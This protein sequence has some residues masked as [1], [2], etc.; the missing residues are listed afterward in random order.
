ME[1]AK[2]VK[3]TEMTWPEVA[4]VD[5]A[6]TLVVA[7]IAACEQHSR[8]LAVFTDAILCGGIADGV[9]ANLPD[10]VL[11]LP[12]QWMGASDHHL[13]FGAT[14]SFPVA[15]HAE[16]VT[17]LLRPF[18]GDG[19]GRFL[20]LNGHGGN[21]DTFHVALR[22]LQPEYPDRL[23]AGACYW[24]IAEKEI[25]ELAT[26]PRKAVG[27]ACE[28]ETAMMMHFRP[29]L[30]RVEE[31]KDDHQTLPDELRGLFLAEDM[32]QRTERGCVGYPESASAEMGKRLVDAI[33][34]RVTVACRALL[35]RPIVPGGG[36][37]YREQ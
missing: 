21:V 3:L 32:G 14:L 36:K 23:L 8:H 28:V 24:E 22:S 4:K 29:D 31:R 25:A 16:M 13:P 17:H 34:Q 26:G 20:V 27:H 30:V 18:L 11:L 2:P 6:S 10:R 7:P 12:T 5:R 33:I 15:A 37:R 1:H 35:E 9:E 19:F